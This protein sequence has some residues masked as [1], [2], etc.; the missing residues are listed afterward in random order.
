MIDYLLHT[1]SPAVAAYFRQNIYLVKTLRDFQHIDE[2]G[3]DVGSDVRVRARDVATL[4]M[5]DVKLREARDRRKAMR[6][7]MMGSGSADSA[8][9]DEGRKSTGSADEGRKG[10]KRMTREE[11]DLERAIKLSEEEEKERLRKVAEGGG[12]LFDNM[13]VSVV[14]FPLCFSVLLTYA[15]NSP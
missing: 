14:V 9:D 15:F 6:E 4:L 7:R 1:G 5:D 10:H 3:K 12:S 2:E 8:L 11:S 13:C